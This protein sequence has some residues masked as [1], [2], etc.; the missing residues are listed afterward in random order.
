MNYF[1]NNKDEIN[2]I[3]FIAKYQY[4][5]SNDAKYFFDSGAYY[6]KR[7]TGLVKKNFLR[8]INSNLVLGEF[9]VEYVKICN[10]EYN[11]LNRN[12][13]YLS[14]LLYLSNLAAFYNNCDN[15]KFTP[16]FAMK[17]KTAYTTTARRF[18]GKFNINNIEYLTYHISEEHNNTYVNSVIY[19]IQK[20][21]NYRNIIVLVNDINRIKIS[22]FAFG[23][24]QVL[25][26]EDS[27]ENRDKLKYINSIDWYNIIKEKYKKENI[28][29]AEYSFC[30]YTNYKDKYISTFYF[31]DTKKINRIQ[32]FLRENKNKNADIICNND[33]K[34]L[35]QKHL[36]NCNFI[37]ID[38]EE[39]IDKEIIVYD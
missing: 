2:L 39:Y 11:T 29:L 20:E 18:I 16:S 5:N 25:V 13:Q 27:N 36:P 22:D 9:G 10:F 6:K 21:R 35:L 3:K 28:Y 8:R 37:G 31:L 38:L 1:P 33:I 26:L 34:K 24:F 17:E 7:I 19:D 32:H 30:E 4:L 23:T 15:I 14:R 12:K